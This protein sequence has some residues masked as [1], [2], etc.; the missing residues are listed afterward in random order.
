MQYYELH[1]L[2]FWY[3][4]VRDLGPCISMSYEIMTAKKWSSNLLKGS[5]KCSNITCLVSNSVVFWGELRTTV[6]SP[7]LNGFGDACSGASAKCKTNNLSLCAL[8]LA[9]N[10]IAVVTCWWSFM[11]V[12]ST[13]CLQLWRLIWEQKPC[14]EWAPWSTYIIS[15]YLLHCCPSNSISIQPILW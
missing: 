10:M 11:A 14:K 2:P 4:Y 5:Y 8:K 7:W 15:T 6:L 3:L 1:S 12:S 13:F 9:T